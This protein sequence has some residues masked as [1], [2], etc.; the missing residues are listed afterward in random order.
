MF[1]CSDVLWIILSLKQEGDDGSDNQEIDMDLPDSVDQHNDTIL[2]VI[3][4]MEVTEADFVCDIC[5][6]FFSTKSEI[7]NHMNVHIPKL[8][9]SKTEPEIEKP[10]SHS[11]LRNAAFRYQSKHTR[12]QNYTGKK[13][14]VCNVCGATFNRKHHLKCHAQTHK[15]I[16]KFCDRVFQQVIDLKQHFQIHR[17]KIAF[18]CD[19]CGKMLSRKD[20]LEKHMNMHTKKKQYPC[21]ICEKIL[22]NPASYRCHLTSHS[23]EVFCCEIC[24]IQCTYKSNLYR[25]LKTHVAEKEPFVCKICNKA[26]TRNDNLKVHLSSHTD[27]N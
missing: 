18:I 9:E 17:D 26:F 11:R 14:F 23:N 6:A 25:H 7:E 22:F 3:G 15:I 13:P 21:S 2:D 1:V 24:G 8:M 20:V 10:P 19:T 12:S 5:D 16:C 27:D 4:K